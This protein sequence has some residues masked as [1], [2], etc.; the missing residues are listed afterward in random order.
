[1]VEIRMPS[2]FGRIA[3]DDQLWIRFGVSFDQCLCIRCDRTEG[4]AFWQVCDL[5]IL[6]KRQW[7]TVF[8]DCVGPEYK[9]GVLFAP[10]VPYTISIENGE[11]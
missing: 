10:A 8:F 1:M 11:R 6:H 7:S 4:L 9:A 3:S 2:E 5:P